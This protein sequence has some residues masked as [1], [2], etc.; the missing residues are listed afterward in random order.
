M[1]VGRNIIMK[2]NFDDNLINENTREEDMIIN[3]FKYEKYEKTQKKSKFYKY[4]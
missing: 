1:G 4:K 2:E 3:K